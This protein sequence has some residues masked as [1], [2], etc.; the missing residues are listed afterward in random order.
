[1]ELEKMRE[2]RKDLREKARDIV[3]VADADGV[4]V[5]RHLW[6]G[7]RSDNKRRSAAAALEALL[8]RIDASVGATASRTP[9]SRMAGG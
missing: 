3:A 6:A 2:M 5:R 4:D 8:E 7:D 9:G 1:M